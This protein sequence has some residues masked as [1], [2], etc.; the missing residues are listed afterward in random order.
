MLIL[1]LKPL[2]DD[3]L[4]WFMGFRSWFAF[5]GLVAGV[6]AARLFAGLVVL[7]LLV[8]FLPFI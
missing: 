3:S 7:G 6:C 4:F 1:I 2:D 5:L 8:G